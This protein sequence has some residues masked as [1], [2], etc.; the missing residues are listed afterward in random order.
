MARLEVCAPAI[1]LRTVDYG[2]RDRIVTLFVVGHGRRG[3]MAKGARASRK[4]F[5]GALEPLRIIEVQ[6]VDRDPSKLATMTAADVIE[7]FPRIEGSFDKTALASYGTELTREIAR[8][9]VPDDPFFDLLVSYYRGLDRSPEDQGEHERLHVGF[10]V[11]ALEMAGFL[12]ALGVCAR[13][14][15]DVEDGPNWQFQP[16][17][18][19]LCGS[20]RRPGDPGGEVAPETLRALAVVAAGGSAHSLALGRGLVL[21]LVRHLVGRDLKSTAFLRMVLP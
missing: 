9:G 4:R 5:A 16:T 10:V 19:A 11:Q 7:A 12:P 18:G 13:C 21:D 8:D 15:K 14:H 1:V 2:D 17:T 20:C 3:V 6:Y